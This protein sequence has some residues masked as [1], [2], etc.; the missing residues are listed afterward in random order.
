M[1]EYTMDTTLGQIIADPKAKAVMDQY[2]PGVTSHPMIGMVSGVSLR[3]VAA[4]PQAAAMGLTEDKI[5]AVLNE[6]NKAV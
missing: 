2:A 5:Q 3:A 4:M 6:I 1:A